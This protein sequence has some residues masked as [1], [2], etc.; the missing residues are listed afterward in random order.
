MRKNHRFSFS[1]PFNSVNDM[2]GKVRS[3]WAKQVC[4]RGWGD[5]VQARIA[6]RQR[7][8]RQPTT[9]E[10]EEAMDTSEDYKAVT[11]EQVARALASGEE[12]CDIISSDR[13]A[14]NF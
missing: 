7:L 10:V 1:C 11:P 3:T 4:L 14:L 13:F 8:K 2:F 5:F 12:V 6:L 9:E